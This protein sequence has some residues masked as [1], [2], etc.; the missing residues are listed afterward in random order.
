VTANHATLDIYHVLQVTAGYVY[1]ENL[2]HKCVESNTFVFYRPSKQNFGSP[3]GFGFYA[4]LSANSAIFFFEMIKMQINKN[5]PF[6]V[7]KIKY[8]QR[9][10]AKKR[11]LNCS[12]RHVPALM[13]PKSDSVCE[14]TILQQP[15]AQ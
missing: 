4:H 9:T 3:F 13:V 1:K 15:A 7:C 14:F 6:V 12:P 11:L 10:S 5:R 2:L 8:Y